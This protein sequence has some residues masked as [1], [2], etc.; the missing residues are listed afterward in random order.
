MTDIEKALEW[1]ELTA[2]M[3]EHDMDCFA[4]TT[5]AA[6]YRAEKE[7]ADKAEERLAEMINKTSD[8]ETALSYP[9]ERA[10]KYPEWGGD[11]A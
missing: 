2:G 9:A 10:A 4:L 8:A 11:K 1:V 5:L 6:A 7:R 3:Q